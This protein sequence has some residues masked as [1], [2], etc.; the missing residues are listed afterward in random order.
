MDSIIKSA[1]QKKLMNLF[2]LIIISTLCFC[3]IR[4][5]FAGI[6]REVLS[7]TG[8]LAGFLTASTRYIEVAKFLLHWMPDA[9][10]INLLSFL[11][12]FFGV[13]I[14]ISILGGI[15]K[16]LLK[17]D[18]LSSVD[19]T[20]GAGVGIVKGVLI[21]SVLLLALTAFLPKDGSIIKNSLLSS[22]F[23][24]VSDKMARIA[25]KDMRHE[26]LAKIA[27]YKKAWENNK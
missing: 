25:S 26:Y 9:S 16:S 27:E 21:V 10:K 5:I 2:D 6:I 17:I 19:R 8:L 4:G 24:L 11:S 14:T 3:L 22:N 12:I 23:T 7:V 1:A 18:I 13:I 20:F 15:V